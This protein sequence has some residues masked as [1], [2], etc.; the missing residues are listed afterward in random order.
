VAFSPDG[1]LVASAAFDGTIQLW[2]VSARPRGVLTPLGPLIRGQ[3][4]GSAMTLGAAGGMAFSPDGTLLAFPGPGR[5]IVLWSIAQ[6]RQEGVPLTGLTSYANALAFSSDGKLLASGSPDTTVRLWSVAQH[7]Q[8]G[9]PLTGHTDSVSAVAFSPN[10]TL[11]AS[12]SFDNT[13]RLWDVASGQPLG[14]PL[15]GDTAVVTSLAFT[16]DGATLY[17]G[18]ADGTIRR[19]NVD[20]SAWPRIACQIA[21]RNLTQQ[22]WQHYLGDA[23]YQKT[24]PDYPAGS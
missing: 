16:A 5:T 2:S 17:S 13:I 6:R 8:V 21:N 10:G 24:C 4:D 7:R 12:S 1:K 3:F 20:L 15:T 22:E 14:A 11:L 18:S 19:W 9:M 23:T